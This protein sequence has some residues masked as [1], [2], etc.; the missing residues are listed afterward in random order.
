[1][2]PL[3]GNS[4]HERCDERVLGLAASLVLQP[5][6]QEPRIAGVGSCGAPKEMK[7]GAEMTLR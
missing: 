5:K 6:A 7:C 4:L 1:M 2:H 3:R